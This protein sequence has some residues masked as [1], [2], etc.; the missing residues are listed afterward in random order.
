M[1]D[2]QTLKFLTDLFKTKEEKQIIAD[3]FE[4]LSDQKILERLL[5][6]DVVTEKGK[7]ND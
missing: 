5:K 3:I 6:K 1:K 7:K 2:N 4:D